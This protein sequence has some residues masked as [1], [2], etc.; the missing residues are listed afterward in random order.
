MSCR[1]SS[2]LGCLLLLWALGGSACGAPSGT[3]TCQDN[4]PAFSSQNVQSNAV[5]GTAELSAAGQSVSFELLSQLTGLPE[6]APALFRGSGLRLALSLRYAEAPLG[7]DGLTQ[8]PRF[9]VA[10]GGAAGGTPTSSFPGATESAFSA[11]FLGCAS[12]SECCPSGSTHCEHAV[13]VTLTRVDGEPFPPVRVAW[14][15]VSSVEIDSCPGSLSSA[16]ILL[17]SEGS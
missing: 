5:T 3:S 6:S 8:M 11:L 7:G 13:P 17:S 4:S 10:F 16:R 2:A 15:A 14:T 12:V 1:Q 9:T